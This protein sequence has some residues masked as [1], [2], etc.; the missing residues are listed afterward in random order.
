MTALP[1]GELA[2]VPPIISPAAESDTPLAPLVFGTQPS[3]GRVC[4]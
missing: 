1:G 3:R 2:L 4:Q